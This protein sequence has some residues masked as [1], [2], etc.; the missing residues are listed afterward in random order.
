MNKGGKSGAG[1]P[2]EP[3]KKPSE[4]TAKISRE[5]NRRQLENL[6]DSLPIIT[7]MVEPRP[8][9]KPIYVSRNINILGYTQQD[10]YQTSG[11][12]IT[13][14]HEDDRERILAETKTAIH[15]GGETDYEY[16]IHAR[17]GTIYWFYDKGR[18]ARDEQ[19]NPVSW[20][21]ILLDISE[22]KYAENAR[23]ESEKKYRQLFEQATDAIFI[24]D[25]SGVLLEVNS[26][27][28]EILGCDDDELLGTNIKAL[29]AAHEMSANPLRLDE[30]FSGEKVFGERQIEAKN[31][32]L[33]ATEISAKKLDEQR[34]QA[35][36]RDISRRKRLE[37]NLRLLQSAVY[38][39]HDS[40]VLTTA[41]LDEPG[42]QIVF[43]NPA[44][45]VMTGYSS[46]EVIGKTPR[47]L[48]GEK[49]D[50]AVL[51]R[52][53]RCLI[54]GKEFRGEVINYRKD[55]SEYWL[56][57]NVTPLLNE[58]NEITHYIAVQQDITN[59]K[60]LEEQLRQS[61]KMEAIGRLAGGVAHD[62]NNLLTVITGYCDLSLP[63]IEKNSTLGKNVEQIKQAGERATNLTR[64]LLAFSRTQIF[65][66]RVLNLNQIIGDMELMLRRLIPE[67][68]EFLVDL[69]E[70]VGTIRADSG[71]IEQVIMNLV[72]NARDAMPNGGKLR[73]TTDETCLR[74]KQS[75]Q[76]AD[77]KP[78]NYVR[79]TI[80]DSGTGISDEVK[81]KIFEPFFTTKNS[82][83]GTGL[84]LSTAYGIVLQSGGYIT[85]KSEIGDGAT[86]FVYL[87]RVFGEDA[88]DITPVA[89][90]E[91]TALPADSKTIL[92]VEDEELVLN[93]V[94]K[95]LLSWKFNVLVARDGK[96][97]F[98]I[99]TR[100]A[101]P[102]DLLISDIVMPHM[103]GRE[104]AERA[105]VFQPQMR[106]LFMS[107]YTDDAVLR[108]GISEETENFIQKPFT[109]AAL[110]KKILKI[111]ID[112]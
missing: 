50:R 83:K 84:G 81:K 15:T 110:A 35:I 63:L 53:R 48:Q 23:I 104:L 54:E 22:R 11:L 60:L 65:Q 78:G 85:V 4:P 71:Q 20:E 7:Y 51:D 41:E 58:K 111:I 77:I 34:A 72:V 101:E 93:M 79:L 87:P 76:F 25:R 70:D 62:F 30:L 2:D 40:I 3:K 9:Y 66:T 108:Q 103:N 42:P 52:M 109:P 10:W 14:I 96:E 17:D 26:R 8:P 100:S 74:A 92:I 49:T 21:G 91:K 97:A 39:T 5:L 32:T 112:D 61:Q 43:V 46:E 38:Q 1:V 98:E 19:G 31:G 47:I 36:V 33:I 75:A 90:T 18:F 57:W 64:Q 37:E 106:V 45:S 82:D 102:I 86:F 6:L 24:F 56:E 16:R 12:W 88:E 69:S 28:C 89:D 59:R 107:G 94:R 105:A 95:I 44:F 80:S 13:L 67:N 29:F 99:C 27:A 55:G 73:I 68:I